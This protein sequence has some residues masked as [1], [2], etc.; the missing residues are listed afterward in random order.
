MM[1]YQGFGWKSRDICG[2]FLCACVHPAVT[3]FII[4]RVNPALDY[5]SMGKRVQGERNDLISGD[6]AEEE[7][8]G[9]SLLS[10]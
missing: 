9:W 4:P 7:T 10:F 6:G 8:T 1:V 5:T 2:A 3:K